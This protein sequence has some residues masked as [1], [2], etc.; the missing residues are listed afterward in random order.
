MNVK[1]III[2]GCSFVHGFDLC[3]ER[4]GIHPYANW[5]SANNQMTID[6]QLE[7]E[8]IRLSGRLRDILG[9]DVTN[10]SYSGESNEY[11]A[12]RTINYINDNI[13]TLDTESTLVILGWTEPERLPF[14]L[15]DNKLNVCISLVKSYIQVAER[16]QP[17]T[18][19]SIE[20]ADNYKNFLGLQELWNNHDTMPYTTYFRHLSLVYMTQLYLESKNIKYCFFNSL[21]SWP[22][23][24]GYIDKLGPHA[25]NYDNLIN[26]NSWYPN[27]NITS[28]DWNWDEDMEKHSIQKTATSHPSVQAVDIFS[29]SLKEFI[30]K[31]Y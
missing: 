21:R 28:Y 29:Q 30:T 6:Q 4:H 11:I 14:Y 16:E 23:K 2:N 5:L 1:K 22:L 12:N 3:F 8:S 9:C 24:E 10:L 18:T 20:R 25:E 17:Q 13:D 26:W 7:F 27:K 19:H 31:N 15:K